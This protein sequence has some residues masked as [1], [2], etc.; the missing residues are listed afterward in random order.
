MLRIYLFVILLSI[1]SF[2][3]SAQGVP[4][5]P[6]T[7]LN[8]IA[9]VSW[10]QGPI[11]QLG[12]PMYQGPVIIYNPNIVSMAGPYITAFFYAHEY[13][14]IQLDHIRRRYFESNPYN[15]AWVSQRHESEADSCATQ[16]LLNQGNINAVRA[17]AQWFY[18]Q[19]YIPQVAS[20][21]PGAARADN[22]V[23]TARGMG[24]RL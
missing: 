13:C 20:H 9:M 4:E 1:V 12:I 10:H 11:P 15:M 6:N 2:K 3:V 7:M 19:G 16:N 21:P 17:A 14:H 23:R 18:G 22:I 8:D 24:V 5:V